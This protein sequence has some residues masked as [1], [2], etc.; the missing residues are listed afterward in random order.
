VPGKCLII[1]YQQ[2]NGGGNSFSNTPKRKDGKSQGKDGKVQGTTVGLEASEQNDVERAS[3]DSLDAAEPSL[4]E[5]TKPSEQNNVER[6]THGSLD[7]DLSIHDVTETSG[8]EAAVPKRKD[9][10]VHETTG[11]PPKRKDGRVHGTILGLE[12]SEQNGVK[13]TSHDLLD[14]N[15][16]SIHDMTG[17]LGNGVA[18]SGPVKRGLSPSPELSEYAPKRKEGKVHETTLG[19]DPSEQNDVERQSPGSLDAVEPSMLGVTETVGH[20]VAVRGTAKRGLSP[21]RDEASRSGKAR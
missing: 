21:K 14:A 2:F 10:K 5:M 16:P 4:H 7:A 1:G 3:H 13:R 18:V 19:L 8:L 20:E 15:K 6:T 12:P 11:N 17:T 9:G